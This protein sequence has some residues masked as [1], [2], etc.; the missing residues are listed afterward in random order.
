MEFLEFY[1]KMIELGE[2]TGVIL[3]SVYAVLSLITYA[4]MYSK[5]ADIPDLPLFT[6]KNILQSCNPFKFSH[7]LCHIL[8][9]LVLFLV[10]AMITVMWP[11]AIPLAL[12]IYL[13]VTTRKRNLHKKKMW[14][15]LKS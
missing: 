5:G 6:S 14:E 2:W 4:Y 8:A 11:I 12:V 15:E 9:S 1:N 3:F 7:P 13:V 10:P